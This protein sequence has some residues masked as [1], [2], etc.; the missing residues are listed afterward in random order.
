MEI[1]EIKILSWNL[2]IEK[3]LKH[4]KYCDLGELKPLGHLMLH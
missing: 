1:M 3:P 4:W 2:F